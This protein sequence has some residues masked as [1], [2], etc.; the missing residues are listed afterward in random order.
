[1]T[2][3]LFTVSFFPISVWRVSRVSPGCGFSVSCTGPTGREPLP[4]RCV[5]SGT[6]YCE[7]DALRDVLGNV[8]G[9]KAVNDRRA[10]DS[11][12]RNSQDAH[13]ITHL[14]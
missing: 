3:R 1:M 14:P 6:A 9:I 5:L 11:N 2:M 12:K 13:D 7:D 4:I 8:N 10:A